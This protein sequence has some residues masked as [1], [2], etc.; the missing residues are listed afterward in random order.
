VWGLS[1]ARVYRRSALAILLSALLAGCGGGGYSKSD[2]VAQ[3]NGICTNTLRQT[4][5]I[6]PPTSASE[7]GALAEYLSRLV[8]FVQSEAGQLRKLKRPGGTARDRLMLSQY[9]AA[10]G[11]VVTAYRALE[12]AARSGDGDTIASVEATLRASPVADLATSYGLKSCG[13]PGATSVG[14]A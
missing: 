11:Q 8:P 14:S 6:T 2:F 5:A 1:N 9:F 10:L 4:R 7:T 12:A 3:A 13:T